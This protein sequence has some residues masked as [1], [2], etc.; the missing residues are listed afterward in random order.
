MEIQGILMRDVIYRYVYPNQCHTKNI[1]QR[2]IDDYFKVTPNDSNQMYKCSSM[3]DIDKEDIRRTLLNNDFEKYTFENCSDGGMVSWG[4]FGQFDVEVDFST[5]FSENGLNQSSMVNFSASGLSGAT[6]TSLE[7]I[8]LDSVS[9][10]SPIREAIIML[11]EASGFNFL[12]PP[13]PQEK[14]K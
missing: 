14:K 13:P 11:L 9:E 6:A 10:P 4:D 5:T 8:T 2:L 12:L 7:P 3:G 1:A